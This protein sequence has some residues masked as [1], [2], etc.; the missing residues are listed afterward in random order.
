MRIGL[1]ILLEIEQFYP[2]VTIA[3]LMILERPRDLR[4]SMGR[5]MELNVQV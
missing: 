4:L 5:T 1:L 2:D 3:A